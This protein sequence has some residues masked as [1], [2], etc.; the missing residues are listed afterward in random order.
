MMGKFESLK[1]EMHEVNENVDSRFEDI[2]T[3]INLI[4]EKL[5]KRDWETH[6]KV[7]THTYL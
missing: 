1:N 6:F 7:S 2:D 4:L 3:K 5:S